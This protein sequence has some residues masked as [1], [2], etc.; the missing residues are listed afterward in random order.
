MFY[1]EIQPSPPLRNYI[2]FYWNLEAEK[3]P[4]NTF[5]KERIFPDGCTELIIHYGDSFCRFEGEQSILQGHCFVV[6][7]ISKFIEVAPTGKTGLLA[8][9]FLP[10][11]IRPFLPCTSRELTDGTFSLSLL[12]GRKGRELEEKVLYARDN[13][14]RIALLETFLLSRLTGNNLPDPL[15]SASVNYIY[16]KQGNLKI[17]DLTTAFRIS[18]RQLERRFSDAVGL[19]PKL[20]SRIIRLQ[21]VFRHAEQGKNHNLTELAYACGYYDQAHFI[22]EFRSFTGQNPGLYFGDSHPLTDH[23]AGS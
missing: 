11:G 3:I 23:F 7:Q 2:R 9:R 18:E 14:E 19:S 1:R 6:G 15:V 16:Q 17:A 22:R 8:I 20:F 4:G 12:F 13:M 21:Q 10:Q 5:S